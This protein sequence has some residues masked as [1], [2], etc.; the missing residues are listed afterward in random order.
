VPLLNLADFERDAL[1]TL[2]TFATIPCL[3]PGFDTE[4]VRNGH[5][6]RAI[7]LLSDWALA[8]HFANFDVEIHRLENRTPVL[9]VTIAATAPGDGTAV[10]Y[11]HLDK[12]PPL[13]DWSEG[14]A[15]YDPVRRDD[16]LYARGVGDDGY[17]TF[18]ALLAVEAMEAQNI[19]HSRCVVLIEASEESG[20]PDLEA[21]LDYLKEHLGRVELM[22]C[23]DSGALTY[24]RLWVTTSLRGVVNVDLEIE[25]LA[26]GQHSGSA[27]GVVPSSFRV[28]R[29]LLDR[30]EDA[31]TGEVLVPQMNAKIPDE[32]TK[33]AAALAAEFGD[34][35]A[36]ELPTL[37]GVELMGASAEERILRRT[38]YPTLSI[39]GLGG[40]P[41]P[42]IAGNVLRP[43]TTAKLSFRLPPSVDAEV[44]K[45][46]L[47]P[48][49]TTNVPSSARV[50][51]KNWEIGSGW[52]SPTLALW[53]AAALDVASTD[54]YGR[55]PGF[56]GEGGSIPFLASLGK[57]YPDVQFV[58]TGV[59]GP[60]SNAHAI[61]EFLDLPMT[62]GITNS[63]I[64]VLSEYAKQ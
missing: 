16:R 24:D 48:I 41:V 44:A 31:A 30:V 32:V 17:S 1:E 7:E 3:S 22:I 52:H 36:R 38:W 47:I 55:A 42:E 49:L 28:L 60:Q 35:I 11:G 57:R 54:A 37:E 43:S 26:Q 53:L 25:V 21:Y 59:M 2:S 15:P 40:A 18:S 61:D 34:I 8:R 58:A 27:S 9:V 63:V 19:P 51:L 10:L 4:W 6:D 62:V 50:T 56:T 12:Q 13:G 14:L 39:I 29:Q 45:A 23:L 46:A 5:I 64:T 33:A 20:S